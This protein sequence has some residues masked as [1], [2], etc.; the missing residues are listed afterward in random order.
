VA[1]VDGV[2]AMVAAEGTAIEVDMTAAMVTMMIMV[3]DRVGR[4]GYGRSS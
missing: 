3:E 1:T 4:G 2:V